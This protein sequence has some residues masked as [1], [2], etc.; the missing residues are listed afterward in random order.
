MTSLK[1]IKEVYIKKHPQSSVINSLSL[2]AKMKFK[3]IKPEIIVRQLKLTNKMLASSIPQGL[4]A[5]L[6][7]EIEHFL[8]SMDLYAGYNHN[9]WL[10]G[11]GSL[12]RLH[13]E[14]DFPDK[15]K[16]IC[17]LIGEKHRKNDNFVDDKEGEFSR[18]YF[19]HSELYPFFK[20]IQPVGE[21]TH[22]SLVA[23]T[24]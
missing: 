2:E 10:S 20:D 21:M 17:G 13:N 22:G 8:M 6:C 18:T 4:K 12:W 5:D 14:P 3:R 16:Y 19:V 23:N 9:F 7:C 1:K 11:G 24:H 15:M